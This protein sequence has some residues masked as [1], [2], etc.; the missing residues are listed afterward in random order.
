[1]A[2]S[3]KADKYLEILVEYSKNIYRK[4]IAK[5]PPGTKLVV[6]DEDNK[7]HVNDLVI[8]AFAQ[9]IGIDIL[10]GKVSVYEM[11][12][13]LMYLSEL[14]F[15]NNDNTFREISIEEKIFKPLIENMEDETV[16]FLI[17]GNNLG[18]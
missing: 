5:L 16:A 17:N 1:M 3:D 9:I 10:G 7:P 14:L 4:S 12:Y 13:V 2:L 11:A 8:E 18:I 6:R 15:G